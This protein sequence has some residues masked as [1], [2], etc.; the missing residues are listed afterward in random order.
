MLIATPICY[1]WL[2][3]VDIIVL[4]YTGKRIYEL[5]ESDDIEERLFFYVNIG[6]MLGVS[7]E[8]VKAILDYFN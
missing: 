3:L 8:I 4:K 2:F 7:F 6:L 5:D 1:L